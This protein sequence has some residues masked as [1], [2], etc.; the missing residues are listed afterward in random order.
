VGDI[1]YLWIANGWMYLAVVLDLF[2]RKTAE[3]LAWAVKKY[4]HFYN[5]KRVHS[6][7][8]AR[9]PNQH[10]QLFLKQA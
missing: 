9:S 10:E 2:S 8:D 6:A 1:T 7:N 4:I 5:T 3:D